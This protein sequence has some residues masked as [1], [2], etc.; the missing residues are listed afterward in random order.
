MQEKKFF[1]LDVS[2][3]I[4]LIVLIAGIISGYAVLQTNFTNHVTSNQESFQDIQAKFN[5]INIK[6][7]NIDNR[8]IETISALAKI[9]GKLEK[10]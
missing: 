6:L 10:R 3:L 8:Q 4:Q 7:A 2:N 5:E 9:Q 1:G